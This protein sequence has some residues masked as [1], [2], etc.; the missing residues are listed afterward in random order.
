MKNALIGTLALLASTHLFANPA[1]QQAP[2]P[3]VLYSCTS[4]VSG[5]WDYSYTINILEETLEVLQSSTNARYR[6][7]VYS[8]AP[9]LP[10]GEIPSEEPKFSC[11]YGPIGQYQYRATIHVFEDS[12]FVLQSSMIGRYAPLKYSI[13]SEVE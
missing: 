10:A 13:L 9:V 5:D 8:I 7:L 11:E 3:E 12:A 4:E 2:E 1:K 6:P